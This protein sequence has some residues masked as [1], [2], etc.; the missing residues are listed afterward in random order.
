MDDLVAAGR[1]DAGHRLQL[2]P[3]PPCL[4]DARERYDVPVVEVVLPAVRRA[5]AATR[6]GRVGVIGTAGHRHQR[7]LRGRLRRRAAASRSPARPARASSTSSSAGSPAAGSCSGWPQSYLDPLLAAGVDTLVLGCTHYPLLTGVLSWSWATTSRWCP[8]PRRRPRTST[9]CSPAP[10]CC[11]TD[12]APPPRAPVPGHRRPRAV[13]AGSGRRFLGPG[14]RLGRCTPTSVGRRVRLTVVGCSGSGPGPT[15][16][17]SCYLVEHD[18][19]RLLL[20]LGNG[21]FGALQAL[22][23]PGRGRRGLPLPPARRP[24]P[25]RRAVRRLAPLL[26]AAARGSRC[27]CTR[28]SAPSGRLALAYDADGDAARPTCSTSCRS[29]RG[30]STLGPFAVTTAR[31]AHP[32]ECYAIRLTAGGRSLVYTGDTGPCDARGRAGRAAPTCCSPRRRTRR[33]PDCRRACT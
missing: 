12:D 24:L 32:V 26:R 4:R 9:G 19:F 29:A 10:T 6:N 1:Q 14:G 28:R 25:R 5:I 20:D 31:T 16:P 33:G 23:R 30:R 2:R 7:R 11:A 18:G 27:R 3:A 15:S 22:R 21:A 13:R 8:A 17:A